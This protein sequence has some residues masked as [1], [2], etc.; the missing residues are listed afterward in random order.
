MSTVM[1]N[2][3]PVD[4]SGLPEHMQGGMQRYI[5]NGIEAGSFMMAVLENDLMGAFGR[6]DSINAARIKDFCSFLYNNA[7]PACFGSRE[8]VR[9]W[10]EARQSQ[11]TITPARAGGE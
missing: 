2:G 9:A 10:I 3:S 1:V 6:A 5:E 11:S 8:K 7:P 4:Y